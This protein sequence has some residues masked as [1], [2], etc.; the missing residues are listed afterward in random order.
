[1]DVVDVDPDRLPDSLKVR[2][3]NSWGDSWGENGTGILV[4]AKAT[5]DGQIAPR[6][7]FAH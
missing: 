7:T 4:G 2:I 5:P 3:W 1:M 6:V